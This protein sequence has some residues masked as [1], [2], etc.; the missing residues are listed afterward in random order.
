MIRVRRKDEDGTTAG[1]NRQPPPGMAN[2]HL[3]L[4]PVCACV[5][6]AATTTLHAIHNLLS[7]S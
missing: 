2:E 6:A 7:F 4:Q 1:G 3:H 5:F